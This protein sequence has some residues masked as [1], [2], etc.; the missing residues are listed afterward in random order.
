MHEVGGAAVK[1]LVPGG[2]GWG[3]VMVLAA[4]SDTDCV[5]PYKAGGM[6]QWCRAFVSIVWGQ[7]TCYGCEA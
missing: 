7:D 1:H 6:A 2:V 3:G 5:V 4:Q